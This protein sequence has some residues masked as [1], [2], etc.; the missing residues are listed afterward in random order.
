MLLKSPA[1]RS[2]RL[3]LPRQRLSRA[4]SLTDRP[5]GAAGAR[6][7]SSPP[8]AAPP[9]PQRSEH[10]PAREPPATSRCGAGSGACASARTHART[11]AGDLTPG[12]AST[13][14]CGSGKLTGMRQASQLVPPTVTGAPAGRGTLNSG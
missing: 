11:A 12:T 9:A 3:T 4:G 14:R 5:A 10:R 6:C 7:G 2:S 13:A 1:A 8:G